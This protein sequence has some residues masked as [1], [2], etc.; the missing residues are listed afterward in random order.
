M[1]TTPTKISDLEE[2][3][4]KNLEKLTEILKENRNDEIIAKNSIQ[5]I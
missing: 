4:M 2:F 1:L 5:G 3:Y